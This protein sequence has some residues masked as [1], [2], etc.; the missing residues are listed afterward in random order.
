MAIFGDLSTLARQHLTELRRTL[1]TPET[2][3]QARHPAVPGEL[4]RLTAVLA[5]YHD[6]IATGFGVPH[7]DE[8]GVRGAARRSASLLRQAQLSLGPPSTTE[9]T[10]SELAGTLRAISIALGCGLDLLASHFPTT[11]GEQTSDIASAITATET[12]RALMHDLAEYTATSAHLTQR[13]GSPAEEATGSLLRAAVISRVFGQHSD[14][15]T[16][17]PFRTTPERVPP[18]PGEDIPELLSN[19]STSVQ[20]LKNPLPPISVATWRYLAIAAAIT[21]DI[22][23]KILVTLTRRLE[24]LH[25]RSS[26]SAFRDAAITTNR[27]SRSWRIVVRTWNELPGHFGQPSETASID[28][29]DLII[30]LGRLIYS[31]S[32]WRPGPRS[33]YRIKPL[34]ELASTLGQ[35]ADLA[36]ASLHALDACNTI[37]RHRRAACDDAATIKAIERN[38]RHPNRPYQ[39]SGR[40]ARLF[41]RYEAAESTGCKATDAL[42]KAIHSA[43]TPTRATDQQAMLTIDSFPTPISA[44]L[45][46]DFQDSRPDQAINNHLPNPHNHSR[47]H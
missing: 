25:E 5:R 7:P 18:Q 30:R 32:D 22:N 26:T 36:T 39:S 11:P 41:S 14:G 42:K 37:A 13:A 44:Y 28:A 6:R 34:D 33:S 45:T 29:S 21:T 35:A 15:P 46:S 20:R 31:D 17:V 27:A 24:E 40:A 19:I 8:H 1:R 2:T 4:S 10:A 16:S 47:S 3:E 12:A 23:H 38:Y 43:A 9:V